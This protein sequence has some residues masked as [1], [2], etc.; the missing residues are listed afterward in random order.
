MR[1]LVIE[2]PSGPAKAR[3]CDHNQRHSDDSES[4]PVVA[5]KGPGQPFELQST[6]RIE[7]TRARHCK[8]EKI[9][10]LDDEPERYHGDAGAHPSEKRS[11]V[12]SVIAVAANHE[13]TS[14]VS[15]TN[16]GSCRRT[17][18]PPGRYLDVVADFVITLSAEAMQLTAASP[19]C[20]L[21]Y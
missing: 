2:Q 3:G 14:L 1:F 21:P 7:R 10:L 20:P 13:K 19:S 15:D 8:D 5:A 4:E 12:G 18:H 16:V 9:E 6:A 11:F 17:R